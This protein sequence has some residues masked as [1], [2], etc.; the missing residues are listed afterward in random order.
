MALKPS[1]D[2]GEQGE[3]GG[4]RFG[5]A[6]FAEP[7]DL[8]K[9]PAREVFLVAAR[10]HAFDQ[11]ALE[12][13]HPAAAAEGGHRAA[14]PVRLPGRETCRHH[15]QLDH[16]LLENRHPE[17]A[18]QYPAHR[19]RRINHGLQ[20]LTA[21]QIR[22]HHIA[23]DGAGAHD[24]DLDDQIVETGGLDARQHRHLGARLDLEHTDGIG[25][26][27]HFV[28]LWIFRRHRGHAQAPAVNI[29]DEVECPVDGRQH[30]Q[31]QAVHF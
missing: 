27:D 6:V 2:V 23:L 4:V 9:Y 18:R 29:L 24:G 11:A 20:A 17:R 26:L 12:L 31:T 28:N 3:A 1:G 14:Q 22:V 15:G 8:M 25:V 10:A 19:F 5:K 7:L 30:A 16:L 21:A 13:S